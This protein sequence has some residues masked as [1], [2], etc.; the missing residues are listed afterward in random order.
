MTSQYSS[1]RSSHREAR[2]I[3][4]IA[5]VAFAYGLL[6][7]TILVGGEARMGGALLI[8]FVIPPVL[9]LANAIYASRATAFARPWRALLFPLLCSAIAL[10]LLFALITPYD[11]CAVDSACTN[12]GTWYI[13]WSTMD[14]VWYFLLVFTIASFAGFGVALFIRWIITRIRHA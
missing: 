7:I 2:F 10:P 3:G 4:C 13:N 8:N 14:Q 5:A 9:L 6:L 12:M 1:S 11:D